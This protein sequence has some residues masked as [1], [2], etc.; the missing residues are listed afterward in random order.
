MM[1]AGEGA[2]AGG[3]RG[4]A[5]RRDGEPPGDAERAPSGGAPAAAAAHRSI[6]ICLY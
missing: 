3:L 5:G 4:E 1:R 6:A 2:A